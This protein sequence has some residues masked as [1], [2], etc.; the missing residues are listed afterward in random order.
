MAAI[1]C[2]SLASFAAAQ[3]AQPQFL[4]STQDYPV[5]LDVT[6]SCATSGATIHYT[7]NGAVPTEF[8]PIVTS[9]GTLRVN[10]NVV[11]KAKAWLGG[12]S[13]T[14]ATEDYRITG[15]LAAGNEHGL[16]LSVSGQGWAWGNQNHGKLGNGLSTNDQVEDPEYV[17]GS[18]SI[19]GNAVAAGFTHSLIQGQDGYVYSFGRNNSGQLGNNSTTDRSVASQVLTSSSPVTYLSNSRAIAAGNEWS[20]SLLSDGSVV[21]WGSHAS[22]RLGGNTTS[23][24]RLLP[25]AVLRGDLGGSPT[26]LTGIRKIA[27]AEAYGLA[28]SAHASETTGGTGKV[29]S[30]GY[31]F[32]GQLGQGN[33][34]NSSVAMPV[35]KDVSTDLEDVLD[36]S[37]GG[38]H[39]VFVRWKAGVPT[40]QG[41]VW[42][43]GNR[44][45]GRL[46][47]GS[48]A[49]GSV[50]FPE[51]VL[52]TGGAALDQIEQ[53]AAGASHT[54]ALDSS[55]HVWSWGYN[56]YGQLGDN[57]TSNRAYAEKVKDPAG[58]GELSDIVQVAAGGDGLAGTSYALASDGTVYVWGRNNE[59]Q[60]GN[61]TTAAGA[62][63]L[64]VARDADL[65]GEGSPSVIAFYGITVSTA[66]GTVQVGALPSHSGP[67]GAAEIEKVEIVL[68]GTLY[69]T[70]TGGTWTKSLTNLPAGTY[71]GYCMAYAYDD[72]VA[73]STPFSFVINP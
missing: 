50:L 38:A 8:D 73:M 26:A 1:G 27:A 36:F 45:Y 17:L 55:G 15:A 37:A 44:A 68:N 35:K 63:K 20:M 56:G 52:K 59:G 58:T 49:A 9:G 42:S 70:M 46:G 2:G 22:G 19:A 4:P 5:A 25:G 60:L 33:T 67:N 54:L 3:V 72:T 31:N 18:G 13:S 16:A 28:R 62:T 11:V 53:V 51:Q 34:T 23:G 12:V 7:L 65:V 24:T 64:P 47:N 43:C 41:T 29:W 40:M 21:S 66:P 71:Y 30:W 6:V 69:G 61:G 57:T 14:V 32:T 10:R 39:A 48:T